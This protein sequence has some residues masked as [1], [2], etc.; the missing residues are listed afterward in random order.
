VVEARPLAA[1]TDSG[2]GELSDCPE[3]GNLA[4]ERVTSMLSAEPSG[5][6][7]CWGVTEELKEKKCLP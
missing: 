5:K 3:C 1:G 4:A 2:L 6:Q 7:S